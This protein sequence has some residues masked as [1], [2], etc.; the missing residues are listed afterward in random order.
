M[1]I[2]NPIYSPQ[3]QIPNSVPRKFKGLTLI[4][5]PG[6]AKNI[7]YYLVIAGLVW[8][9]CSILT[10]ISMMMQ[11][12]PLFEPKNGND[13]NYAR[14]YPVHG[15]LGLFG[16]FFNSYLGAG[17]WRSKK[18]PG[19]STEQM[20]GMA[21]FAALAGLLL[22][23]GLLWGFAQNLAGHVETRVLGSFF[24]APDALVVSG[25][26]LFTLIFITRSVQ[27][28]YEGA[29]FVFSAIAIT[30]TYLVY[31]IIGLPGWG[32]GSISAEQSMALESWQM[33]TVS[34]IVYPLAAMIALLYVHPS[35]FGFA[36][37]QTSARQGET[38]ELKTMREF[39]LPHDP[40]RKIYRL[41]WAIFGF[42]IFLFP[43][44]MAA[45]RLEMKWQLNGF[46]FSLATGFLLSRLAIRTRRQAKL[47]RR[48]ADAM[49]KMKGAELPQRF[50]ID[51]ALAMLLIAGIEMMVFSFPH[52]RDLAQYTQWISA[53]RHLLWI[54]WILPV[55][56]LLSNK[57]I[58][59][60]QKELIDINKNAL[61]LFLSGVVL[62][63]GA[64]WAEGVVESVFWRTWNWNRLEFPEWSEIRR[65]TAVFRLVRLGGAALLLLMCIN[66]LLKTKKT[67]T[68]K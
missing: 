38:G 50:F 54:G 12:T 21:G 7:P 24:T 5:E 3:N 29:T 66:F 55:S 20:P 67:G 1:K 30:F 18:I 23:I 17:L 2:K 40:E 56:I 13:L 27:A 9:F 6:W 41:I 4:K 32:S 22:N 62:F 42:S 36:Q 10:G 28:G 26:F 15:A 52:V 46:F 58:T 60:F 65:H 11:I 39:F 68:T 45:G 14:L 49:N 44:A 47:S 48:N 43:V 61:A 35:F 59:A 33:E 53:H 34:G 51:A 16:F 31:N 63:I 19:L 8:G 64:G 25:L 37:N 57:V